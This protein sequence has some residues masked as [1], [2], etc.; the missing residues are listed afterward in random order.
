MNKKILL[1]FCMVFLLVFMTSC[2]SGSQRMY[3]DNNDIIAYYGLDTPAGTSG[4]TYAIST[5]DGVFYMSDEQADILGKRDFNLRQLIQY[6]LSK[7]SGS[8]APDAVSFGSGGLN[9]Y[10]TFDHSRD[11]DMFQIE[12]SQEF[13][14]E[15]KGGQSVGYNHDAKVITKLYNMDGSPMK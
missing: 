14:F 5:D 13:A 1:L 10:Y 15:Y 7:Y 8:L 3:A 11:T 4:Y 12:N 2:V 6:D 9:Y